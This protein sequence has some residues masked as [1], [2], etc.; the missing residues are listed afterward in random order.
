M[1]GRSM[2]FTPLIDEPS[3]KIRRR[4]MVCEAGNAAS[5]FLRSVID[6]CIFRSGISISAL[7]PPLPGWPGRAGAAD[8]TT[9]PMV[10]A[11]FCASAAVATSIAARAVTGS[12]AA[13]VGAG[14]LGAGAAE[15]LGVAGAA[16]ADV[17]DGVG[18]GAGVDGDGVGVDGVSEGAAAGAAPTRSMIFCPF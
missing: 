9:V 8:Q 1:R 17:E 4:S 12:T 7:T 3:S 16:V 6:A 5:V 10:T 15:G 11:G 14:L 2:S 18:D 13:T